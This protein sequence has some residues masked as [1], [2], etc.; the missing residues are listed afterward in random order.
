M[1]KMA[2]A[3]SV[4]DDQRRQSLVDEEEELIR[5]AIAESQA[6]ELKQK[7]EEEE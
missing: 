3:A 6:A 5:K 7:L 1:F 2:M 4:A